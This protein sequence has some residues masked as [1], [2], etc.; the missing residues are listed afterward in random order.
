MRL[1]RIGN[2]DEDLYQGQDGKVYNR[3]GEVIHDRKVPIP[4]QMID[5]DASKDS[6]QAS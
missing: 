6:P 4:P 3:A 2:S 5:A 1:K